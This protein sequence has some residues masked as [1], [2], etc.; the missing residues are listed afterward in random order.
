MKGYKVF[1]SDWTCRKFKYEVGKTYE[2][3]GVINLCQE[4]FHFCKKLIDCFNY[5]SFDPKNKVAEI[6]AEGEIIERTDKCVTSKITIIKE[7]T[8]YEVL[9]YVNIGK[10]NSGNCNSG[11]WNSG[12]WNSGNRNSGNCNS[13]NWNSGDC[14]S[15]N[16][17]SGNWNSGNCNSGNC[18]S[19]NCNSGNRNSGNWNSGNWNS[20]D[21]NSGNR[22]SG[23]WNSGNWNSGDWNSAKH[24]N[25]IFNT[26]ETKIKTFDKE[27]YWTF[28][29]W[30]DSKSYK[31]LNQM[32]L[33]EWIYK[34]EMTEEEKQKNP[35]YETKGGYLR[36][37]EYKEACKIMWDK[38]TEEEKETVMTEI[39]NFDKDKFYKITGIRI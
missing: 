11:N 33:T 23:N 27:S 19:G 8:W 17:N 39:P 25:G 28:E 20:G 37:Y 7:L 35:D 31:I 26:E 18:N 1:N 5:Y 4:G 38:L 24:S 32:R 14:N 22:N 34:E 12:N 2:H 3:K 13:G 36:K 15:G 16:W 9:D 29:D 30:I 21:C 10:N 6:E